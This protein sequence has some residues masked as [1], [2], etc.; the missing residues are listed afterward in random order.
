MGHT[1]SLVYTYVYTS[2]STPSLQ[3]RVRDNGKKFSYGTLCSL[4]E[5]KEVIRQLTEVAV[6]LHDNGTHNMHQMYMTISAVHI[7]YMHA[8]YINYLCTFCLDHLQT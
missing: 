7:V 3:G 5:A 8:L 2:P 1:L 6:Y 4:Q